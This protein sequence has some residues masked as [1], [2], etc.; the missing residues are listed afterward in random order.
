M[1]NINDMKYKF[2][3]LMDRMMQG[4]GA[5]TMQTYTEVNIKR[6]VQ[7]EASGVFTI[8]AGESVDLV[9][10]A[11]ST[12]VILKGRE[13]FFTGEQITFEVFKNPTYTGGTSIPVYNLTQINPVAAKSSLLGGATVTDAGTK[14]L[15]DRVLLGSTSV[16]NRTSPTESVEGLE[17]V[18][19]ANTTY[20]E[21]I[22]NNNGDDAK[23]SIYLTWYEGD[24]DF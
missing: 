24:L 3:S 13:V 8:P 21:R 2:F 15:A 4:V 10:I 11:G 18:F 9:Y 22:T 17:H 23:V 20:L 14:I 16:G 6:G 19:E 12:P 1:L 5:V 7:Y